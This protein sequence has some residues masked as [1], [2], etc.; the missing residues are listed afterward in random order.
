MLTDI[1]TLRPARFMHPNPF[2]AQ[3]PVFVCLKPDTPSEKFKDLYRS[4]EDDPIQSFTIPSFK[5]V[6]LCH[7][8]FT[9]PISPIGPLG[10]NCLTVDF[11][12]FGYEHLWRLVNVQKYVLL[13]ELAHFYLG[14][15]SLGGK[16]VPKEEY[17]PNK[18]VNFE[19]KLSLRNPM[20]YQY[21]VASK[22]LLGVMTD[23]LAKYGC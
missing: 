11:N 10:K 4:C 2:K 12:E 21:F 5:Y 14:S 19:Q 16:T 3:Y 7:D 13:H 17:D 18:C 1:I 9:F 8:F 22:S 6:F 20:N 23:H 15:E